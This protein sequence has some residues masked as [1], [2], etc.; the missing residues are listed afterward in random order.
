MSGRDKEGRDDRLIGSE[1]QKLTDNQ[2]SYENT[3][4]SLKSAER[5][6]SIDQ[7]LRKDNSNLT[8]SI[9]AILSVFSIALIAM[10]LNR[11]VKFS[12]E[13]FPLKIE[14]T[15]QDSEQKR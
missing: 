6:E 8:A 9:V 1:W 12:F 11:N 4:R 15:I 2:R 7:P 13:K 5:V 10:F 3:G 14:M